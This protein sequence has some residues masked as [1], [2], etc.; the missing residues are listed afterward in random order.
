[1]PLALASPGRSAEWELALEAIMVVS[2][3]ATGT[4]NEN[5]P[6]LGFSALFSAVLPM[7]CRSWANCLEDARDGIGRGGVVRRR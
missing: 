1:V 4:P 5:G 7:R 3:N 2:Q 6:A